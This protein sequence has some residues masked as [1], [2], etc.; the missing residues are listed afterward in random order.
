M[1]GGAWRNLLNRRGT[2]DWRRGCLVQTAEE[3]RNG[4]QT[5]DDEDDNDSEREPGGLGRSL[6]RRG[7]FIG[8]RF[9][10]RSDL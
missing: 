1:D 10:A 2:L 7:S 8:V 4:D 9:S 5:A 3:A 6:A